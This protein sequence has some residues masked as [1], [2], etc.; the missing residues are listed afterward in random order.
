MIRMPDVIS[1]LRI[2]P[3]AR[4]HWRCLVVIL[5]VSVSPILFAQ[6]MSINNSGVV[7][8]SSAMLDVSS[9][10]SGFLMP[11]MTQ[12]QR[13]SIAN[14][15]NGLMV[16]Q[17]DGSSGVYIYDTAGT[18]SW[19]HMLDSTAIAAL[20]LS[21]S[22]NLG[23]HIA[24][25]N[26]E[27]GNNYMSND[28]DNEGLRVSTSGKVLSDGIFHDGYDSF[29]Y[30]DFLGNNATDVA[31][32][33][34]LTLK[35]GKFIQFNVTQNNARMSVTDSGVGI[36]TVAPNSMLHLHSASGNTQMHIEDD[37]GTASARTLLQL[38]NNG[39]PRVHFTNMN[40]NTTWRIRGGDVFGFSYVGSNN[41][42][43]ALDTFG[44]VGIGLVPS[45]H[46]LEVDGNVMAD[47]LYIFD[48]T[49]APAAGD[50]L[51]AFGT[52]GRAYW[53]DP[54]SLG[55]D[56]EDALTAD[57]NANGI[58]A[59]NLGG[60]SIGT[61]GLNGLMHIFGEGQDDLTLQT[62]DNTLNQGI[63]FQNSGG[64]YSWNIFRADA[65]GSN[66]DLVISGGD[67]NANI[68]LLDERLRILSTGEVGINQPSPTSKLHIAATD[69]SGD[70]VLDDT[71]PF[72]FLNTTSNNN[73]GIMFRDN[74]TNDF[75][76]FYNASLTEFYLDHYATGGTDF[77]IASNGY[78]GLNQPDP[79]VVL[80]VDGG[81]DAAIAGSNGY[82]LVND[83]S[84]TNLVIDDNEIMARNN[85]SAATLYIQNDGGGIEFQSA[86]GSNTQVVIQDDGDVGIGESTPQASLDVHDIAII[87][88]ES[89]GSESSH[90]AASAASGDGFLTTPWVYTYALHAA[91]ERA[92]G[93]TLITLGNIAGVGSSDEIHFVTSGN[94]HMV[95]ESDGQV[96]IGV[97]VSTN[98]M[99]TIADDGGD[100]NSGL[101]FSN[102]SNE[103][104]YVYQNTNN[105]LVFRDDGSDRVK[106]N[107][108]GHF[109]PVSD[110]IYDLGISSLRWDDVYA[111]NGSIQTSDIRF[112]KNIRGLNYGLNTV[113]SLRP[114]HYQW[115]DDTSNAGKIGFIAQ[116]V[117]PLI[118]EV[119][120]V[121]ED[122][123]QTLGMRYA[124]MIPILVKAIQEQQTLIEN[125]TESNQGMQ[126]RLDELNATLE[127]YM[128]QH[129][130]DPAEVKAS[131]KNTAAGK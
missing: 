81:S 94:D 106:I 92:A 66:A 10:T 30:V 35:A 11:R 127:S 97:G 54:S 103:D 120:D 44:R 48:G 119:V 70:I 51:T 123:L 20:I 29:N 7:P 102:S 98:A 88:N 86:Q 58:S 16:I 114:V 83:E 32:N 57:S 112:K 64:N 8:D 38:T 91:N 87:G 14:P 13:T 15:A 128:R 33:D 4:W 108:N 125:L 53:S 45:T 12:A 22:D 104:W 9:T 26:V 63:A 43:M 60:L 5:C 116:E 78:V 126:Q 39:I 67:N 1:R 72:L 47:S 6:N 129:G 55:I 80:H 37:N 105:E 121:G 101:Q 68:A 56:F 122:S 50:V 73:G 49:N 131:T 113:L 59:R 42:E 74:G 31:A 107:A 100:L 117:L 93:G 109:T 17:T 23:D 36:G 52:N 124:D 110:N 75:I 61:T 18:G 79:T 85:G 111:T 28:G 27:L 2:A 115:K 82:I 25:Q 41:P 96:G 118:P 46:K 89:V 130:T 24:T 21:L 65:S 69:N 40:N 99:L 90:Q 71:F 34:F 3:G 76:A 19:D 77:T 62:S 84:T 95:I